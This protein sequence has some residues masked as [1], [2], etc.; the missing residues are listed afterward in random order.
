MLPKEWVED[1]ERKKR[2]KA[3]EIKKDYFMRWM[4]DSQYSR[5]SR[6]TEAKMV[7]NEKRFQQML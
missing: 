3:D 5:E 7:T 1:N 6:A 4:Q 2:A